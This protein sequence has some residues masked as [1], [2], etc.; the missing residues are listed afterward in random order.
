[1]DKQ[2]QQ[3]KFY[4]KV[5]T[6]VDTLMRDVTWNQTQYLE[7][8]GQELKTVRDQFK[9]AVDEEDPTYIEPHE[10]EAASDGKENWVEIFVSLYSYGIELKDWEKLLTSINKQVISRPILNKE[11][12]I[13]EWIR[14]KPKQKHEAYVVL[15]VPPENVITKVGADRPSKNTLGH[16]LINIKDS[17]MTDDVIVR[18]VHDNQVYEY[19]H[20]QLVP[21]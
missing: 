20:G 7:A 12:N 5:I 18:F 15:L 4:R 13:N 16:D 6:K 14:S 3:I 9:R 19:V 21:K 11:E 17:R 10:F 8:L 1:M 2:P